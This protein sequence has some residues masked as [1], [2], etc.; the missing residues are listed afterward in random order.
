MKQFI[1]ILTYP[2][3]GSHMLG[4]AIGQHTKCGFL[5]ELFSYDFRHLKNFE[6]RADFLQV[7]DYMFPEFTKHENCAAIFHMFAGESHPSFGP[8]QEATPFYF[9][10]I[11][12]KWPIN[13]FIILER[14]NLLARY[15][16]HKL[17]KF[18]KRWQLYEGESKLTFERLCITPD[19]L[20]LDFEHM[21]FVSQLTREKAWRHG[22]YMIIHYED[23]LDRFEATMAR[24][25]SF[26]QIPLES[27]APTTK[28]VSNMPLS[29]LI[30]NWAELR[31]HFTGS[32]YERF[33]NEDKGN[34]HLRESQASIA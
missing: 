7:L 13:K 26:Y 22:E 24:V 27:V 29:K 11:L 28:K 9:E 3:Q 15:A 6:K 19:E 1:P 5:G 12:K 10:K 33:F 21:E 25:F 8:I 31:Q 18:H 32:Q 16:S 2:R 14:K 17:A 23:L 30:S 34:H 20:R 4:T